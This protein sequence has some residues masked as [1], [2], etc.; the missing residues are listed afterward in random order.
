MHFI[1]SG[2]FLCALLVCLISCNNL[3]D[4]KSTPDAY[5]NHTL[6]SKEK[7][8]SDSGLIVN[9]LIVELQNHEEFFDNSSYLESTQIII[10]SIMYSPDYLK[11]AVFVIV[12]NKTENQLFPDRKHTWYYDGTCY[13]GTGSGDSLKLYWVGPNFTESYN[14]STLSNIIRE[15]CYRDYNTG[16]STHVTFCRYN[17]DDIRFWTCSIWKEL[18][19]RDM[20]KKAFEEERIKHP[21]N[22]YDPKKNRIK[23]YVNDKRLIK[24]P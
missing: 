18:V 10:D 13:L 22:V 23:P 7:Y 15:S 1:K 20:K 2:T 17:M 16:D 3:R 8:K 19:I 11:K 5:L 9:K 14:K 24:T 12:K 6:V 21:E 4:K